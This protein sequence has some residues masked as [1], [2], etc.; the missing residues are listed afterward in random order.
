M[1]ERHGFTRDRKIGKDRWVVTARVAA[2][3]AR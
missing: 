1:F 3:R 2:R